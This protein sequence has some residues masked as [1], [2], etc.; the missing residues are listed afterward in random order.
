MLS[1]RGQAYA[2][3]DLFSIYERAKKAS[4]NKDTCP[5]GEVSFANAEN[6]I[7]V[8]KIQVALTN[9]WFSSWPVIIC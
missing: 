8:S 5:D 9:S 7:F 1:T 4:Y 6:V 2:A 3:S